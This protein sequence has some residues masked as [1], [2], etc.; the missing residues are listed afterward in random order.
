MRRIRAAFGTRPT[1]G[2]VRHLLNTH[3]VQIH[4]ATCALRFAGEKCLVA[5]SCDIFMSKDWFFWLGCDFGDLQLQASTTL[6]VSTLRHVRFLT[7]L[8]SQ[9]FIF[10][11]MTV[12]AMALDNTADV[13]IED[14]PE[15]GGAAAVAK[16]SF[17]AGQQVFREKALVIAPSATNLARVR[18]YCQLEDA[19]RR[20]LRETFFSEAPAVRCAATAACETAEATGDTAFEVLAALHREGWEL[21][22]PEV[23]EVIR[24][25]NL[26]AYDNALAPVACKVSHSCAP[27]LSIRVDAENGIIEGTACR[28]IAAGESLGIPFFTAVIP[29][30]SSRDPPRRAMASTESSEVKRRRVEPVMPAPDLMMGGVRSTVAMMQFNE[31]KQDYINSLSNLEENTAEYKQVL[32][33]CH[34]RGAER[35]VQVANTNRGLYVKAAQFIASIRGGTGERGVP[36]AYTDALAKFTDHA[37][38]KSIND[39]AEALKDSMSLGAWPSAPLDASCDLQSI[40]EEPI[41]SASL[42]QVHRA[43]LKDG[44]KVAVKVQYPELRKEMSSDFAVF[45]SMGAVI[46]QM[47]AGYDLMWVVE[48]FEQNLSRELDFTLEACN[49]EETARQL[50]HRAPH[51]YVPKANDPQGL[52]D[53]GLDVAECAQLICDTFAEMIFVHGR[54]IEINGQRHPQLVLLDHGLYYDLC[55]GD[56]NVRLNFCRYWKACC[57]KDSQQMKDLGTRFAGALHRFLP[58][59]LSPWFVFGGSGVSLKEVISAAQG[60]LPDTISL[61]LA[62]GQ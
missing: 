28:S 6:R 44:T 1:G 23:E 26:N 2:T 36:K 31:Q 61:N 40:E 56:H 41:A 50:K 49:G 30:G 38:H 16:A 27:N 33:E 22:L 47:A 52:R 59:I 8:L 58:L 37:P 32:S 5:A 9:F 55:E 45:K 60:H 11:Q 17:K 57:A 34:H 53:A 10:L 54:A 19:Q 18:A 43:V 46:K 20:I 29:P 7:G 48:D 35:C 4:H 15:L 51:V 39:V 42:A 25:W 13:S 24:V 3:A 62:M 21:E 12:L 14:L